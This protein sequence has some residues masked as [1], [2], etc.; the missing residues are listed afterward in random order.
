MTF[1]QKSM[2]VPVA[3]RNMKGARDTIA[4]PAKGVALCTRTY[5]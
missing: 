1:A 2:Y 4:L 5:E 3:R